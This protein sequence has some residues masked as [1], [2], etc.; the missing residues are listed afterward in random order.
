[1]RSV[2]IRVL[3]LAVLSS[4]FAVHAADRDH[5]LMAEASPEPG[6]L[7]VGEVGHDP[8]G[9][10]NQNEVTVIRYRTLGPPSKSWF[11]LTRINGRVIE[12]VHRGGELGVLL[13]NGD[14]MFVWDDGQSSGSRIPGRGRIL[15]MCG[16]FDP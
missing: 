16:D 13:K 14:W 9:L 5:G 11:E 1:M 15:T 7:W 3:S 10:P 6:K 4:C 12:M 2:L 8:E